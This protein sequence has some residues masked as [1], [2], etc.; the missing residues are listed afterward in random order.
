MFFCPFLPNSIGVQR[1]S[2]PAGV[3]SGMP[4]SSYSIAIPACCS[5]ISPLNSTNG[6]VIPALYSVPAVLPSHIIEG[7]I[8]NF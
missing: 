2:I 6:E 8:L 5:I 7:P 1:S 3:K 4:T